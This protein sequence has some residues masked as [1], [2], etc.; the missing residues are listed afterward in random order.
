MFSCRHERRFSNMFANNLSSI[1][2]YNHTYLQATKKRDMKKKEKL[3]SNI[4]TYKHSNS[5]C[6]RERDRSAVKNIMPEQDSLKTIIHVIKH[7]CLHALVIASK[8][9]FMFSN[10]LSNKT[11]IYKHQKEFKVKQQTYK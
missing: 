5:F 1:Y 2:A 3:F 9:A 4:R 10:I 8:F 7:L 11:L 6:V